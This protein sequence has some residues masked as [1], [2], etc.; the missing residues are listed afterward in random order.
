MTD[1]LTITLN[2]AVDV[3]STTPRLMPAHKMRC[4]QT[5]R[6]PGGGGINVTRVLQR[7]GADSLALYLAGGAMGQQL[8]KLVAQ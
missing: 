7:L 6:Y 3:S 1:I 4:A 8:R 5:Q 2:P